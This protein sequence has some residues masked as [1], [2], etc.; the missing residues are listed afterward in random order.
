VNYEER[1]LSF[2]C[3]GEWLVGM[4]A[5]PERAAGVAVVVIVGG[6]QYRAGSHRQF[7]R[8][9]RCLAAAGF[10]VLRFDYR[11]MG[12][13][14]G[15]AVTFEECGPDISAA[16]AAVRAHCPEV[17]RVVLWGLCDAASAALDY[18]HAARDACVAGM[19]LLNPWVRSETTLAKTQIKHY[20]ARR[21][22]AK[23][24]WAKLF[25]G[26]VNPLAALTGF[27]RN[28]RTAV[29]PS[30][31]AGRRE[32]V[33]FQDRM[34]AAL[35]S[36]PGPVLLLLSGVDLTAR[37]F[38]E[39]ARSRPRWQGVLRGERIERHDLADADH[40][41]SSGAAAEEVETRTL[42]WL[43]ASVVGRSP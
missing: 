7:V 8:L 31:A 36:F 11:G 2:E 34:A 17:E 19:V 35:G 14:T 1:P 15:A 39:Y 13:S 32:A 43:R 16:I 21:V 37:E 28:L 5:V 3:R 33:A 26:G 41:F 40:T 18:W 20:Y 29:T 4:L 27:A 38:L 9:A 25:A 10:P 42:S 22:F 24:F 12:D 30:R 23:D 6:P